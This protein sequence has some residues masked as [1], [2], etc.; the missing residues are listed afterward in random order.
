MHFQFDA[1]QPH[2]IRAIDAVVNVFEGQESHQTLF[3]MPALDPLQQSANISDLG[4]GNRLR[5]LDEELL[6]NVQRIQR[7]NGLPLAT[8]LPS[9]DFTLEMETGTGKTYVYLRSLFELNKHYGFTKFMIVVPSLA[10]KE[11]VLKFLEISKSH[12][13]TLYENTPYD[14]FVYNSDKLTLIRQ[15][16]TSHVMQIMVINIDAFRKSLKSFKD[17]DKETSANIIHRYH[18]KMQGEPIEFICATNPIVIIDEP[19]S[20]ANTENSAKAIASLN[21]LCTFRYSATHKDKHTMLYK[22]D[23]IDAYQQGLV[24]QIEV[25]SL[26]TENDHNKAYMKLLS[27]DNTKAPIT[28]K[29]EIDVG[30]KN[31]DVKRKAVTVKKGT[32]LFE[33]SKGRA[34][35]EGYIIRDIYCGKGNEY[36]DFTN[37]E[38]TLRLGEAIGDYRHDDS[39]KRLQIRITIEEHLKKELR[40]TPK[41]IKVLSLFFID[42]VKNYRDYDAPDQKGKYAHIFEEEYTK[43][44]QNPEYTS[45]FQE[46]DTTTLAQEVHNGYFSQDKKG[47]IEDTTGKKKEDE[48]TYAL[49]MKEKEKLLSFDSKVKFIFS[50]S[51]LK[52]GWDNPNV[53]QICTLN[54]TTS[55][56]K[57]RQEI[58]RG[59][60]LCVNQKGE[61]VTGADINTLTVITN[62]S[63]EDFV[64]D[65]QKEIE[66]EEGIKFGEVKPDSFAQILISNTNEEDSNGQE[67]PLGSE[68]SKKIYDHLIKKDYITDEGKILDTLKVALKDDTLELPEHYAPY[69]DAITATLKK[70][71]GDLN[72]KNQRDKR[73]I[74]INEAVFKSQEFIELWDK[75]KFKTHYE[76][77]FTTETLIK[78]CV[79]ELKEYTI[80]KPQLHGTVAKVEMEKSAITSK[81]DRTTTYTQ[82]VREYSLPNILDELQN[83][84]NL[85]RQTIVDILLQSGQLESFKNNPQLFLKE[86]RQA[87]QRAQQ[88]CFMKGIKY[89]KTGDFYQQEK[90]LEGE[91]VGYLDKMKKANEKKS[92]YDHVVYDSEVEANFAGE[93]NN[94]TQVKVYA[95]LPSWFT[96]DTP[97]GTYNPDWAVLFEKEDGQEYLYLVVETK[98]TDN[99]ED[100]PPPQQKKIECGK[101]HFE[102]LEKGA[103]YIEAIKS[104]KGLVAKIN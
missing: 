86:A 13:Q 35:Y 87:F 103:K 71:A 6:S 19:Q 81:V 80:S 74:K 43:A 50:H 97:L 95:K 2:Q 99:V 94:S 1:N 64:K 16:A 60:R 70:I 21:P 17:S 9:R 15:F 24:K 55:T 39:Y 56:L 90:F 58:G 88:T 59:L 96:I 41:G 63:Y 65:L 20:V 37:K 25:A 73:T 102:A 53:F 23:S 52:E 44:I 32:D 69:R 72:I 84:T 11:G 28:A 33:A 85:K 92:V 104:F 8:K 18:D 48:D 5:L 4:I 22:L 62:D 61:R 38:Y 31:G 66:D 54:E 27:V 10:I 12:F 91:L 83:Q 36:I 68:C 40:L 46:V 29:I 51:A 30:Q 93:L 7:A 45:L 98:G 100:L 47:Q 101:K 14:Y 75:I 49:I 3:S 79:K 57:K 78:E 34:L 77:D 67:L 89:K 82:E 76:V 26:T 42:K